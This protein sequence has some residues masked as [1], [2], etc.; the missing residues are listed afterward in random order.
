[1]GLLLFRHA[2][3]RRP[4]AR[5]V[6]CWVPDAYGVIKLGSTIVEGEGTID[7]PHVRPPTTSLHV[8]IDAFSPSHRR[9]AIYSTAQRLNGEVVQPPKQGVTNP[10][11]R[12]RYCTSNDGSHWCGP[13]EGIMKVTEMMSLGAYS[14]AKPRILQTLSI[15]YISRGLIP[16]SFS[17]IRLAL[18][19]GV[20]TWTL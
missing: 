11:L 5:G 19:E 13:L 10:T 8:K 9:G 4:F 1:L 7:A 15:P 14:T 16:R 20:R 12:S 3:C 2:R 6:E 18:Y 17:R